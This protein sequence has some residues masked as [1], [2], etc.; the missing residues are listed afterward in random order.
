VLIYSLCLISHP[1]WIFP[2][3]VIF[4]ILSRNLSIHI[5]FPSTLDH[6]APAS[7]VDKK[8][9]PPKPVNFLLFTILRHKIMQDH[10][11]LVLSLAYKFLFEIFAIKYF[12]HFAL[13]L[14]SISLPPEFDFTWSMLFLV[15]V[16]IHSQ[17]PPIYQTG[18]QRCRFL[19]YFSVFAISQICAQSIRGRCSVNR[20]F[21][22][23]KFLILKGHCWVLL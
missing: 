1:K 7:H 8:A 18:N 2:F 19:W 10:Y 20:K 22:V 12:K 16:C 15:L 6:W 14:I 9:S 13:T 4:I 17:R 21:S 23:N 3:K 11:A 5:R